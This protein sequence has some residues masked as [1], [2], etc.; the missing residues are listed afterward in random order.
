MRAHG[1]VCNHVHKGMCACVPAG[2]CVRACVHTYVGACMV[3]V[4]AEVCAD[5]RELAYLHGR[6]RA[7]IY[8]HSHFIRLCVA[9]GCRCC[10]RGVH[11]SMRA[12]AHSRA[13]ECADVFV[14]ICA[15]VG[16]RARAHKCARCI[17]V[18]V[19][20]HNCA[21][22]CAWMHVHARTCTCMHA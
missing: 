19:C 15:S 11:P 20:G 4:C 3:T 16:V 1:C 9:S 8:A 18:R 7:Y 14:G 12:S 13:R 10:V 5:I 17:H 22:M 21:C 6:N 2:T